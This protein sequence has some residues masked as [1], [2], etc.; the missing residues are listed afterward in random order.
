MDIAEKERIMHV[1]YIVGGN[2]K[3]YGSEVIAMELIAELTKQKAVSYTVITSKKGCINELCEQLRIANYVVPMKFYVYAKRNHKFCDS[4]KRLIRKVQADYIAGRAVKKIEYYVDMD[5]VDIIH[6][7]LSR[8]L[9]GGMLSEKH[10]IPHIWHIQELYKAHYRLSLLKKDQIKWMNLHSSMFICVSDLTAKE[11]IEQGIDYKK[12][13]VIKNGIYSPSI[14]QREDRDDEEI[15]IIMSGEICEGK[16]QRILL[17]AVSLMNLNV[18]GKLKID[19]FGGGRQTYLRYLKKCIKEWSIDDIVN[20][21]GYEAEIGSLLCKYDL[22]IN[23]SRG[24]AF[25]LS[26][27]EFM[28]AGLCVVASNTGAN[29]EIITDKVD[30]IIFDFKNAVTDLKSKLEYITANKNL[31][32]QIGR[33]A[34]RN[35]IEAYDIKTMAEQVYGNYAKLME[36]GLRN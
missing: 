11:W 6:T 34:R 32:S 31:I 36:Q 1:L 13:A 14:L 9:V 27:I 16:G 3:K 35:V 17:Q 29:T 22:G 24:E 5:T 20:I 30:G 7:N 2:G 23:C 21:K 4:V 18:R 33:T 12:V 25:G 26:T 19:L 15:R 10:G 8:D 28:C